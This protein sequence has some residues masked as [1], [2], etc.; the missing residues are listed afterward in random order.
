M[1]AL[2]GSHAVSLGN[3]W[4]RAANA[5]MAVRWG[6]FEKLWLLA[7]RARLKVEPAAVRGVIW[8]SACKPTWALIYVTMGREGGLCNNEPSGWWSPGIT[9]KHGGSLRWRL[10]FVWDFTPMIVSVMVV[11]KIMTCFP[12]CSLFNGNTLLC[13]VMILCYSFLKRIQFI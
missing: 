8:R 5:K 12:K 2:D 1:A 13:M 3:E 11:A 10:Q 9:E 4:T 7:R 6:N